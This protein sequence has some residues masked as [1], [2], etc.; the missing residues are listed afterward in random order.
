[1]ME[2]S[3]TIKDIANICGVGVSTVSRAINNHPDINEETKNKILDT[4][5]KY[6]YVPNNSAR[7]LKISDSKTIVALVKG[8]TNPLFMKMIK[9]FE[10]DIQKK[11]YSL[12]LHHVDHLEDEVE[13]AIEVEKE[14]RPKGIIFLGGYFTHTKETLERIPVPFVLSTVSMTD[15]YSGYYSS[16]SVD[17]IKESEKMVE[18]LISLGHKKIL[19]IAA[20]EEDESIG[21]LRQMGYENALKKHKIKI[22]KKLIRYMDCTIDSYS[23]DNGYSVMKKALEENIDFTAVYAISDTLAIGACKA[24]LEAG[25]RIPEDVSVAGFDGIEM[26]KYYNPTIT[27]IQQPFEKMAEETIKMLFKLIESDDSDVEN[28]TKLFDGE[29]VVANS[30]AKI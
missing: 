3:I 6:N 7:S 5:K 23:M 30:T 12:V 11:G 17:D 28:R 19:T 18:Y 25:K 27:T 29:L 4:I 10:K 15:K 16:I 8:I 20:P 2:Q 24:L 22:D 1:M 21:R 13:V 9:V 14:K 26:S